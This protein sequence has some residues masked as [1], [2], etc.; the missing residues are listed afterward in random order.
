M[1][2]TIKLDNSDIDFVVI[3]VDAFR[4][5][6]PDFEEIKREHK[7]DGVLLTNSF[8][9]QI[10]DEMLKYVIENS[11]NTINVSTLRN[12]KII[13]KNLKEQIIPAGFRVKAY[14][15]AVCPEESYLSA[16]KR[17]KE[18]QKDSTCIT[19]F[20][21]KNFH[22]EAYKGMNSTLAQL[23]KENIPIVVCKR[24]EN[25]DEPAEIVV[26]N[27]N[28]R[29]TDINL[30]I[31]ISRMNSRN[32]V[33]NLLKKTKLDFSSDENYIKIDFQEF[34]NQIN[35]EREREDANRTYYKKEK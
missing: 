8:A 15:M 24:A 14:I 6:H 3:D 10:E 12:T 9:F 18:Q 31:A 29:N 33:S 4:T 30:A 11:L 23:Q 28:E 35:N 22:D 7:K 5:Y 34:I 17:F 1:I 26:D 19:R 13:I 25:K 27:E 16:L 21:S 2:E 32:G 20:T